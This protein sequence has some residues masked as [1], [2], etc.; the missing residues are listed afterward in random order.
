VLRALPRLALTLLVAGSTAACSSG[1]SSPAPTLTVLAAA[2]LSGV[3]EPLQAELRKSHPGVRIRL[4]YGGSPS[5]VAQV[6]GGAPAD[7][8]ITASPSSIQPLVTARLVSTP[9]TVATNTVVLVVPAS[10]PGGV[11]SVADLARR[12]L[13]V[14]L[15]DPSV[16][17]GAA[18][19]A[20]LTSAGVT[21]APDTLAPDVKTVL[22]LV[23]TGEA[24]V[25]M[26]YVTDA[27]AAGAAVRTL[28]LPEGTAASTSYPAAVVTASKQQSLAREYVALLL[29]PTGR[30]ALAAAGFG[31]P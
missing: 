7:V 19:A 31:A 12:P 3:L 13:R 8:L 18:A 1:G 10:N 15:C 17:C 16:P 26:V 24:D 4:S 5:L 9:T 23:S 27:R 6:R 21:A 25:G 22:R 11:R 30:A 2:S 20:T 28:P 29:S 14:A